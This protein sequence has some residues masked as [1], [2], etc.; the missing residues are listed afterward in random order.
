MTTK[1]TEQDQVVTAADGPSESK[2]ATRNAAEKERLAAPPSKSIFVEEAERARLG[3]L[4]EQA[5]RTFWHDLP[6]LLNTHRRQWVAYHGSKQIA[7]GKK[8]YELLQHCKELGFSRHEV[9]IRSIEP[10]MPGLRIGSPP[11]FEAAGSEC[12]H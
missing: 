5:T 7:I 11:R 8:K 3:D 12:E 6:E 4:A 10:E 1:L 9:L 2:S